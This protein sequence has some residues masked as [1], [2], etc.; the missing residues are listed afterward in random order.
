M[1]AQAAQLARDLA[2]ALLLQQRAVLKHRG[3]TVTD[4]GADRLSALRTIDDV[5]KIDGEVGPDPRKLPFP[6]PCPTV[7]IVT[8]RSSP[9]GS[10]LGSWSVRVNDP[11]AMQAVDLSQRLELVFRG[12]FKVD[13]HEASGRRA[14]LRRIGQ[15]TARPP[16]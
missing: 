5:P 16:L 9:T 8:S 7:R 6:C 13:P 3:E 11:Q 4:A 1:V 12:I 10:A 15:R 14:W 2:R